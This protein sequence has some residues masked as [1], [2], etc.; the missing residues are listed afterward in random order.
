MREVIQDRLE[1]DN[2]IGIAN[3]QAYLGRSQQQLNA[4]KADINQTTKPAGSNGVVSP[5]L[6]ASSATPATGGEEVTGGIENRRTA[7]TNHYYNAPQT[8][9]APVANP[10][11]TPTPPPVTKPIPSTTGISPWWLLVPLALALL[12]APVIWWALNRPAP[13]VPPTKPTPDATYSEWMEIKWSLN[14]PADHA[15]YTE[16]STDW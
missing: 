3:K 10:V 4:L 14:A 6:P 8:A 1:L 13:V 11:V 15:R 5:A 2:L 7:I 12:A 16:W 9:P